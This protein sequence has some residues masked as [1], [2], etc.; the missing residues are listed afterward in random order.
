LFAGATLA[1]A[2]ET[3]TSEGFDPGSHV[4]GLIEAGAFQYMR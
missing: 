3:R 4:V 2:A 1:E